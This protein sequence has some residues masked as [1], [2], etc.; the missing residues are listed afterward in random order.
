M[1]IRGQY[2]Q[3]LVLNWWFSQLSLAIKGTLTVAITLHYILLVVAVA[4]RIWQYWGLLAV[5]LY[6]K[7]V[8]TV[9]QGNTLV[10]SR[11]CL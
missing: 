8:L 6:K 1:A 3:L 9:P 4:T 2:L 7:V 10:E 11:S 5:P